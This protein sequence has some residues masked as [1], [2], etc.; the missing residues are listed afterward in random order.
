MQTTTPQAQDTT[1]AITLATLRAVLAKGQAAHPELAP[2]MERAAMIVALRSISPAM[3]PE[4][5]V[6]GRYCTRALRRKCTGDL[7]PRCTSG[8][9]PKCTRRVDDAGS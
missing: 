7:R 9:R 6:Y 4:M 3:A 1:P 2:R 8:L 5:S